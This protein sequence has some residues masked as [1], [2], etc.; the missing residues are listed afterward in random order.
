MNIDFL[1][2][3]IVVVSLIMLAIPGFVLVK[4]KLISESSAGAFSTLVL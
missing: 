1:S 3:L 4:T 2:V